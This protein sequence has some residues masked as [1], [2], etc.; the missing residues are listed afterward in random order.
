[1]GLALMLCSLGSCA[2]PHPPYPLPGVRT[3]PSIAARVEKARDLMSRR[4]LAKALLQWKILKTLEPKNPEFAHQLLATRTLVRTTANK[5]V[6]LGEKALRDGRISVARQ[7]FLR[8]LASDPTLKAP[9]SHLRKIE[10]QQVTEIQMAKLQRLLK[11]RKAPAQVRMAPAS[12]EEAYYLQLG[13][14]LLRNGQPAESIREI[15]KY[16]NSYPDDPKARDYLSKAYLT[17]WVD[18]LEKGNVAKA[19][20]YLQEARKHQPGENSHL[21]RLIQETK[22]RLAEDLYERGVRV[23]RKD[24]AKAIA[25]WETS[26]SY[27]PQHVK[28]KL[29]LEKAYKIRN[30]LREIGGAHGTREVR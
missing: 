19:L 13:I 25:C 30:T 2:L 27:D 3:A 21:D 20:A 10:R 17:L 15:Q 26:L 7:E 24:I 8:A 29:Q 9:L 18:Y 23:Y 5:H 28:A 12:S 1:L 11:K 22:K 6:Q 16:L 4:E 14:D